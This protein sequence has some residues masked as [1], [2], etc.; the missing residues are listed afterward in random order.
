MYTIFDDFF[1]AHTHTTGFAIVI[2][3]LI[4]SNN[5]MCPDF[6]LF[7]DVFSSLFFILIL[8]LLLC[9]LVISLRDGI[10]YC[11]NDNAQRTTRRRRCCRSFSYVMCT[12]LMCVFCSWVIKRERGRR[13]SESKKVNIRACYGAQNQIST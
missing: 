10:C 7:I 3:P 8:L 12:N 6:I 9:A 13:L 11:N 2:I 1:L 4:E 5:L